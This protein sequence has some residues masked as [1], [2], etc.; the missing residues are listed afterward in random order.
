MNEKFYIGGKHPVI[1]A[2]KNSRRIVHEIYVCSNS[3]NVDFKKKKIVNK[4]FFKKIFKNRDFNHQNIAALV[5]LLNNYDLKEEIKKKKIKN[6]IIL[7]GISDPRNIGSILRS[8]LAFGFEHIVVEK[9]YYDQKNPI[10]IKSSSGA[11]EFLKIIPV[12]NI[13]NEIKILKI[14][15][16]NIVGIDSNSKNDIQNIDQKNN[17][18]LIFGS[19]GEGIKKSVL[20]ICD[21]TCKININSKI[22]S[23]NVSN[24]VAAVLGILKYKK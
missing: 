7:N 4:N 8:A 10:I 18:A 19:E 23:L 24:A 11:I 13:K 16:F 9:K 14:N 20:E 22:E 1:N 3:T 2:I 5:S 17:N 6:I 15:N 12:S 21:Y